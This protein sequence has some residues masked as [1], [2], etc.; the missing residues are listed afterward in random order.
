MRQ[1][2]PVVASAQPFSKQSWE[3]SPV[4]M[5]ATHCCQQLEL[6]YP[7]LSLAALY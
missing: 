6:D 7:F 4:G 3:D 1:A 2:E 5:G